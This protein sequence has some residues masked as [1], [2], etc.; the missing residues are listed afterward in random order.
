MLIRFRSK[1]RLNICHKMYQADNVTFP[2]QN[3]PSKVR[4]VAWVGPRLFLKNLPLVMW[5]H[6]ANI[7][8]TENLGW[9]K[10]ASWNFNINLFQTFC[11]F[12]CSL[13]TSRNDP[14][15]VWWPRNKAEPF[16]IGLL[17]KLA[18]WL[19][20]LRVHVLNR[21]SKKLHMLQCSLP[22]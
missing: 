9:R 8:L 16:D 20:R 11:V 18:F 7:Q 19:F 3:G 14:R 4:G 6:W 17:Q 12:R 5:L 2:V 10:N 21:V 22:K 1:A 15:Q 13:E